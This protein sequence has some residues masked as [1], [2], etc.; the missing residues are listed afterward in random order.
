MRRVVR[1]FSEVQV[2]LLLLDRVVNLVEE[3]IDVAVRIGALEDSSLIA[4]PVSRV[5]RVVCASPE[6]L[7]S[8]GVPESPAELSERPCVVFGGLTGGSS[9]RF[10]RNGRPV[11][12]RVG[13][14]F[15]CNHAAAATE[16]CAE[17]LGFGLFLSYQV[18][19]LVRTGKLRVVLREWEP[20]PLPVSVVHPDARLMPGRVRAFTDLLKPALRDR[21]ELEP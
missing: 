14:P 20:A 13:G 18:E 4:T 10:L 19:G 6:R 5:R 16:A 8:D 15:R 7:E 17:G 3:G 2:E 12:V 1:R 21:P 9:W 11:A